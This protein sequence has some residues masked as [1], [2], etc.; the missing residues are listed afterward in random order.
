M[1]IHSFTTN[2]SSLGISSSLSNQM[3]DLID[4]LSKPN[5]EIAQ[6]I[7]RSDECELYCAI[8]Y[9]HDMRLSTDSRFQQ[10]IEKAKDHIRKI[11]NDQDYPIHMQRLRMVVT[12][13]ILGSGKIATALTAVLRRETESNSEFNLKSGRITLLVWCLSGCK[14][15]AQ[16]TSEYPTAKRMAWIQCLVG[17]EDRK[18]LYREFAEKFRIDENVDL[19]L[20]HGMRH[21]ELFSDKEKIA[22]SNTVLAATIA[23][24]IGGD[25]SVKLGDHLIAENS[26]V[27]IDEWVSRELLS[28]AFS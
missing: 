26:P 14:Q 20:F 16:K 3:D 27:Q 22:L 5:G 19:N 15:L 21:S 24:T 7:D 1:S 28:L 6:F 18:P 9:L 4:E 17:G 25:F 12:R 11:S 23:D 2:R 10:V 8:G 13:A